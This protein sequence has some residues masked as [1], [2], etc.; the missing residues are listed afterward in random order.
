[1]SN[2]HTALLLL[3]IN[4]LR[5]LTGYRNHRSQ[6]TWLQA[7]S[8]PCFVDSCGRPRVSRRVIEQRLG[9]HEEGSNSDSSSSVLHANPEPRA[10]PNFACLLAPAMR[11]RGHRGP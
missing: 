11:T 6:V 3:S 5:E 1:M 10:R 2:N 8:I 4:E 9:V 7:N